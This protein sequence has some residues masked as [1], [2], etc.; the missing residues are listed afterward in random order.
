M[1]AHGGG[2]AWAVADDGMLLFVD[3]GGMGA[4]RASA[5]IEGA[6]AGVGAVALASW[7]GPG[8]DEA[9]ARLER[10]RGALASAR[11]RC[12]SAVAQAR[13]HA[14]EALIGPGVGP[15]GPDAPYG[16]R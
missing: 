7:S 12:E 9:R 10:C 4:V 13:V 15:A 5:L 6:V 11:D 16:G 3:N 2:A 8:S 1:D 14:R